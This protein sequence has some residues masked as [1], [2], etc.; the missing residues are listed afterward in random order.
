VKQQTNSYEIWCKIYAVG[1]RLD[2]APFVNHNK[3]GARINEAGK[4]Q[5]L[6]SLGPHIMYTKRDYKNKQ[7]LLQFL[8]LC[9]IKAYG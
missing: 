8:V 1:G 6:V 5:V 4:T 3:A 9:S 2:A 7:P